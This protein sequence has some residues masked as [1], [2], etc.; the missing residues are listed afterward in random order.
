MP[1][2]EQSLV[3]FH[4]LKV[5]DEWFYRKLNLDSDNYKTLSFQ[6]LI[7][8]SSCYIITYSTVLLNSKSIIITYSQLP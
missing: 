7:F 3:I 6:F 1:F 2:S 4:N 5:A 8:F